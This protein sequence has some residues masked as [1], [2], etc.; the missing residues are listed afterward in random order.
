[1]EFKHFEDFLTIQLLQNVCSK[2]LDY[3]PLNERNVGC[4]TCLQT[5]ESACNLVLFTNV[6]GFD[7]DAQ[8]LPL[9]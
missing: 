1:M 3:S 7:S 5:Q 4:W 2:D 9:H 8:A 6:S